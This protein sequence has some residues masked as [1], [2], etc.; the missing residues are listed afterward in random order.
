MDASAVIMIDASVITVDASV[1][2]TMDAS[3]NNDWIV[4]DASA[5]LIIIAVWMHPYSLE[6]HPL[7]TLNIEI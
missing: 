7:I 1:V 3:T 6:M 2:T 5:L 4:M